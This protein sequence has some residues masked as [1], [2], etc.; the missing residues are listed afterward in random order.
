MCHQ[1]CQSHIPQPN[2]KADQSTMELVGY[3]T[4]RKE[5]WD[6][7]HNMYLLQRCLV[8]PS[9]GALG[10]RRAIQDKLSSLQARLQKQTYSAKTEGPGAHGRERVGTKPLQSYKVAL[11]ATCQKALETTKALC[12]DLERLDDECRERS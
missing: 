8:S 7:Y 1:G 10:R 6:I 12:H 2:P 11:W 5:M 3:Q 9:C 4:S